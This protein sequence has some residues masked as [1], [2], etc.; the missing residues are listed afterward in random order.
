MTQ[1]TRD[2]SPRAASQNRTIALVAVVAL[3][4][5]GNFWLYETRDVLLGRQTATDFRAYYLAGEAFSR[6]LNP[7][8]DHSATHPDLASAR[9]W[10]PGYSSFLYPPTLLPFYAVS[11]RLDMRIA[12]WAWTAL[13]L[14]LFGGATLAA[15]LDRGAG[16]GI[17]FALVALLLAL[18]SRPLVVHV[19]RGQIDLALASIVV[20]AMIAYRR[21]YRWAA[22][23]LLAVS[24]LAKI[25]PVILLISF[26]V[27]TRD[28]GFAVRFAVASLGMAG[29]SLLVVSPALYGFY[30]TDV[31]PWL[32]VGETSFQSQTLV[33][34]VSGAGPLAVYSLALGGLVGITWCAA[35]CEAP[36]TE[37][38]SVS[39]LIWRLFLGNVLVMLLISAIAW[40]TAYV[41]TLI[42]LAM[43]L[44]DRFGNPWRRADVALAGAAVLL[45]ARVE[46][47]IPIFN[48]TNLLGALLA[49]GALAW[50]GSTESAEAESPEP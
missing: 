2:R 31:M 49:I 41:W 20:L 44:T 48:A 26:V 1:S 23:V 3:L 33:R 50:I 4:I 18:L 46:Q 19:Q 29:A 9:G 35:R 8:L 12:S 17:R 15:A 21:D 38:R 39:P 25:T 5:L 11:A 16:R 47:H 24:A 28:W 30:I 42:P 27:P 34:F 32:S 14:L 22:A 40:Y 36:G 6:G 37:S 10:N 7:Y 45:H 13:S 43:V